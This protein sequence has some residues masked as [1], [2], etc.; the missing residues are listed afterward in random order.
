MYLSL[1]CRKSRDQVAYLVPPVSIH[2]KQFGIHHLDRMTWLN[3]RNSFRK[4]RKRGN[5]TAM[6]HKPEKTCAQDEQCQGNY[7]PMLKIRQHS[8]SNICRTLHYHSPTYLQ[9]RNVAVEPITGLA[10]C[11]EI[12]SL[13]LKRLMG[14]LYEAIIVFR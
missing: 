9:Y 4:P 13:S 3:L 7:Q 11:N 8:K 14:S 2:I 1:H 10:M 12:A 5:D 6:H